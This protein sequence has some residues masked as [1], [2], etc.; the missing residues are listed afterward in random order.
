MENSD[1]SFL[2][3]NILHILEVNANHMSHVMMFIPAPNRKHFIK[4]K[5]QSNLRNIFPSACCC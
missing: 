5:Q 2:N 4:K 1:I 3:V